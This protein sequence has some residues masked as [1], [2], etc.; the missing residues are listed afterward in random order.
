M[1]TKKKKREATGAP[2]RSCFI[3]TS[4]DGND[5]LKPG[6]STALLESDET[7]KAKVTSPIL[8][9]GPRVI[10]RVSYSIKKY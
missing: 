6:K 3:R 7:N 10:L 9:S 2:D 1:P 8:V 5:D 4:K